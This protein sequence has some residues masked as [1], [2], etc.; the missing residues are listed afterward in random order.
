M[1]EKIS[2]DSSARKYKVSPETVRLFYLRNLVKKTKKIL[3]AS[4]TQ[5][6]EASS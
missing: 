6:N 4:E 3:P 1:S 5:P 2:L